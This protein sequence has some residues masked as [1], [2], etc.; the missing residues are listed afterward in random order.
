MKYLILS[1]VLTLVM[2]QQ[3]TQT[4]QEEFHTLEHNQGQVRASYDLYSQE[5]P[6]FKPLQ[7]RNGIE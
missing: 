5:Q 2:A 7:N 3:Q 1:I 6:A 4:Q